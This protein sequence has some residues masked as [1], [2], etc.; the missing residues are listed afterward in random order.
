[1]NGVDQV[2]RLR[3]EQAGV[4]RYN[5]PTYE[6]TETVLEDLAL[7]APKHTIPALEV[8]R[9]PV[10]VEPTL[11]WFNRWP[12]VVASDRLRVRGVEY[13]VQSVPSDWRGEGVGGLVVVL[14]D[15]AEGVP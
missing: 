12:D 4:D 10:V 1:M 7:F 13:E 9:A 15:S 5:N 8:G 11:Y 2:T 14:R 3:R 6:T